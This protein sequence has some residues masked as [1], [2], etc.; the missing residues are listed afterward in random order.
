MGDQEQMGQDREP[1]D[2]PHRC[3]EEDLAGIEELQRNIARKEKKLILSEK[4]LVRIHGLSE[5]ITSNIMRLR[6]AVSE[7]G[8][9]PKPESPGT[10]LDRIRE[11]ITVIYA[12]T[13]ATRRLYCN[14][15]S[16]SNPGT[17]L[18]YNIE[19]FVEEV[20][21]S[22]QRIEPKTDLKE[23]LN[24]LRIRNAMREA[25]VR[26]ITSPVAYLFTEGRNMSPAIFK[27]PEELY[28]VGSLAYALHSTINK[29]LDL[30]EGIERYTTD[31]STLYDLI[32]PVA[33]LAKFHY[34]LCMPRT[35][36]NPINLS[37]DPIPETHVRD[38]DHDIRFALLTILLD[39]HYVLRNVAR[40]EV[41]IGFAMKNGSFSIYVTDNGPHIEHAHPDRIF[42]SVDQEQRL[43]DL[44]VVYSSLR[45]PICLGVENAEEGVKMKLDVR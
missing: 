22:P 12:G 38:N 33:N 21:T 23:E 8:P 24:R 13:M 20:G 6:Q 2:V 28:R 4:A 44:R 15:A 9:D 34:T 42:Y 16:K 40:P 17:G 35:I 7:V 30:L 18:N 10:I 31:S 41:T 1:Y 43:V 5:N 19:H 39:K 3:L 29:D 11:N 14:S 27:S 25:V 45:P 32:Q 26:D 37:V 36:D